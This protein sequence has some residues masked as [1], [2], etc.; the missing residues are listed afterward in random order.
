MPTRATRVIAAHLLALPAALVAAGI[1]SIVSAAIRNIVGADR[2]L[3]VPLGDTYYVV[4]HFHVTSLVVATVL[5]PIF[6][7][8]KFGRPN[9]LLAVAGIFLLLHL[10]TAILR[11]GLG[12]PPESLS[13]VRVIPEALGVVHVYTSSAILSIAAGFLGLV[14]SLVGTLRGRFEAS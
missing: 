11:W 2:H 1:V 5:V 8:Y 9:V 12:E 4:A 3:D 13:V 14:L 6:V 7:A 10:A